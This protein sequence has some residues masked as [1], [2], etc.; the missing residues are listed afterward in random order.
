M[1][2]TS[3]A[4]QQ[5]GNVGAIVRKGVEQGAPPPAVL[6]RQVRRLTSGQVESLDA[7]LASHEPS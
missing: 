3:C 5:V 4:P 1:A 6:N 7:R 2:L